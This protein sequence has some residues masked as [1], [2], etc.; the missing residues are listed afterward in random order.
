MTREVKD[1]FVYSLDNIFIAFFLYKKIFI[2][3]GA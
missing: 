3:L 2:S 1:N